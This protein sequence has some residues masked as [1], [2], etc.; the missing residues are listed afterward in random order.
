MISPEISNQM[1]VQIYQQD[2]CPTVEAVNKLV[3]VTHLCAVLLGRRF[4]H[5]LELREY[6][7]NTS[8]ILPA[9]F[10]TLYNI[11]TWG[12]LISESD[13]SCLRVSLMWSELSWGELSCVQT[14]CPKSVA[15]EVLDQEQFACII[16]LIFLIFLKHNPR[17]NFSYCTVSVFNIKYLVMHKV[18]VHN[19]AI[20]YLVYD[21]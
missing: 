10:D 3:T 6:N 20:S 8:I 1:C 16:S 21:S 2:S 7:F 11:T 5:Q 14:F 13:A 15:P 4:Q 9:Y 12:E 19:A 17:I 18:Q